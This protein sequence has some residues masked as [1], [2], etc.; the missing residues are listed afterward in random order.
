M[1]I[2]EL[3]LL[4][5][6]IAGA[7]TT[8]WKLAALIVEKVKHCIVFFKDMRNELSTVEKHTTEN[9][10]KTLQLTIMS[11]EMPIEERLN[12]GEKYVS[13]GGNGAVKAKY[14]LLQEE[15]AKEVRHE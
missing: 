10:M 15:Y 8:I 14:K 11:E 9:Y 7:I 3:L 12:A 6:G 5:A 13:L 4:V 2:Y 1:Q